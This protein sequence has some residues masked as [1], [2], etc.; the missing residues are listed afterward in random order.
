[1][2]LPVRRLLACLVASLTL[3]ATLLA[4]ARAETP[5][6]TPPDTG[7]PA[8]VPAEEDPT[9]VQ[10]PVA[11]DEQ[12]VRKRPKVTDVLGSVTLDANLDYKE[13]C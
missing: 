9:A 7:T 11:T 10:A 6:P 2:W 4:P 12:Q 1:M 3:V 5:T 13:L 8:V